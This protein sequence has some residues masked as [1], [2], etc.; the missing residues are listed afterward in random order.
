MEAKHSPAAFAKGPGHGLT[1]AAAV[2][3]VIAWAAF[4]LSLAACLD[5][6]GDAFGMGTNPIL[7]YLPTMLM[8]LSILFLARGR[9]IRPGLLTR[10]L[11]AALLLFVLEAGGSIYWIVVEHGDLNSSYLG[12]ALNLLAVF[13]G[14]IIGFHPVLRNWMA[15]HLVLVSAIAGAIGFGI[16]TLHSVHL[17]LNQW[18]QVLHVESV[19]LIAGLAYFARRT[20]SHVLTAGMVLLCIF[21]GYLA[22]KSTFYLLAIVFLAIGLGPELVHFFRRVTG[23]E[24]ARQRTAMLTLLAPIAMSVLALAAVVVFLIIDERSQRYTYDPRRVVYEFRWHQFLDSPI[25]GRFFATSANAAD[26]MKFGVNVPSHNDIL[27]ALAASGVIGTMLILIV[28]VPA[29]INRAAF[30][31]FALRGKQFTPVHYFWCVLPFYAVAASGNPFFVEPNL[32]VPVWF[33]VG[34]MLS[35]SA[36]QARAAAASP[37][38]Q[39]RLKRREWRLSQLSRR[40]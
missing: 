22:G 39:R 9:A 20:S 4:A 15:R 2:G 30:R 3:A 19:I 10:P 26:V 25:Y 32:I 24:T 37:K 13:P 1:R 17:V 27:D 21:N 34:V 16:V 7:K 35:Y 28:M 5:P 18:A 12:R 29:V 31:S 40:T 8:A 23:R 14:A 33:S 38:V 6:R 11:V 36:G